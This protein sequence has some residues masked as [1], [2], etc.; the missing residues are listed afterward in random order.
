MDCADFLENHSDFLDRRLEVYPLEAYRDHIAGCPSCARYDRV[1][2]RGLRLVH[3]IEPTRPAPDFD[4]ALQNRFY[5]LQGTLARQQAALSR[6]TAVAL[7]SAAA[8]VLATGLPTLT[9]RESDVDLPPVVVD[10]P[11]AELAGAGVSA[12]FFNLSASVVPA[13]PILVPDFPK[14]PWSTQDSGKLSLFRAPLRSSAIQSRSSGAKSQP[15]PS[16]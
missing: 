13:N 15:A 10:E 16:E 2:Q 5:Q 11:P 4:S 6:V 7:L 3:E 12:S 1:V 8:L 9:A 14:E